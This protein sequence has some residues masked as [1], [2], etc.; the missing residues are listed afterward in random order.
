MANVTDGGSGPGQRDGEA[1][2]VATCPVCGSVDGH[3][4]R[5]A[6]PMDA[7]RL[8]GLRGSFWRCQNCGDRFIGPV[9]DQTS[10]SDRSGT[11]RSH[12]QHRHHG[13]RHHGSGSGRDPIARFVVPV[14][15]MLAGIIAILVLLDGRGGTLPPR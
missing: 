11:H 14:L 15:L 13:R 6:Y 2:A 7:A 1:G 4:S 3:P 5:S 8:T 9:P 10:L 12:H